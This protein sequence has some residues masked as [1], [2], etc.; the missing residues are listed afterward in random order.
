M[1]ARDGD[2]GIEANRA[3]TL[4]YAPDSFG[5]DLVD[6]HAEDRERHH[7]LPPHR[8]DIGD[9]VR[10]GDAAEIEGVVHDRHEEVGGRDDAGVVVDLPDGGVVAGLSPD[11]K[12]A[13][14]LRLG[15]AEQLLKD[16]GGASLQPQPPPWARL[17]SRTS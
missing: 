1:A 15:P 13:E 8:V 14:G 3:A 12:L 11:Q 7:G 4:Q 9:G 6:G 10:R 5:R 16:G 17:V 2:S